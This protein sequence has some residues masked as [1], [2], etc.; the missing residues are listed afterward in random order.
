VRLSEGPGWWEGVSDGRG[1]G[2][3]EEAVEESADEDDEVLGWCVSRIGCVLEG[4]E[5][6]GLKGSV[7]IPK[8]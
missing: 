2:N 5:T 8:V 1:V 6:G 4:C 3:S 7:S